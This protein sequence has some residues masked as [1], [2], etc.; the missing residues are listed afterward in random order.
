[1]LY[2]V[3]RLSFLTEYSF[4]TAMHVAAVTEI[5]VSLIPALV[6]LRDVLQEK[7]VSFEKIIKIGRTHLQVLLSSSMIEHDVLCI[8]HYRLGCYPFDFGSRVL[9][10][11]SAGY[12]RYSPYRSDLASFK[13]P[14]PRRNSRWYCA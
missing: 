8:I 9:R 1:M 7:S 5:N 6:E 4:P 14:C 3:T 11:C 13:P 2:C 10:L 12:E